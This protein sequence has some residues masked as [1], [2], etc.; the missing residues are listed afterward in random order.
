MLVTQVFWPDSDET[1][2]NDLTKINHSPQ[3][4][5]KRFCNDWDQTG[6]VSINDMAAMAWNY[7]FEE[8]LSMPDSTLPS[9]QINIDRFNHP[10][11]DQLSVSWLGHSSL[12]ITI[13]GYRVLTDPVFEKYV[14]LLGPT[15]YC[16]DVPVDIDEMPQIDAVVISHNH[17]DHFSKYSIQRLN[18]KTNLFFVPLAV[19]SRLLHWGVPKDKI[20]E[21]DWWEEFR[22]DPN[23]RIA[24]TP[25]QHFSGRSLTDQNRTLWSSWVIEGPSHN[26]FF[27]GDTGYFEGFKTIGKKYGPFD[28]TF[29]ECGA[30]DESWH[31]VH[32][33]P[34]Q[35]VQAH[36]DLKGKLLHPIHWG[37]FKLA[38]HPWFEP[39]E[40]LLNAADHSEV[41]ALTPII[42]ETSVFG[43][44]ALASKWW[45]KIVSKN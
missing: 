42:G 19:G 13:D 16:G 14:S 32:M 28:M 17:H 26:V 22:I 2:E 24:A 21:M 12:L 44:P 6:H 11:K 40:R 30:Y 4:A 37:T 23:L 3:Y 5:N 41:H 33:F 35:A 7:I 9:K 45:E 29:L 36:I 1:Y 27:S 31:R 43:E 15:R 34:E 25:A 39:M 18:E 20:I 38:F 10:N 8:K